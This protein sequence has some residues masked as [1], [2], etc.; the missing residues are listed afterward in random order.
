MKRFWWAAFCLAVMGWGGYAG[1]QGPTPV[2]PDPRVVARQLDYKSGIQQLG[3]VAEMRGETL[4]FLDPGDARKLLEDIWENPP[5]STKGVLGVLVPKGF[6]PL[7]GESWASVVSYEKSG[8]VTDDDADEIDYNALLKEMQEATREESARRA[9]EGYP[10]IELVGWASKPF[11]EKASHKLHWA[12]E[13]RFDGMTEN[14]LNYNLRALGRQG[15]L[16]LNFVAGMGQLAEIRAAIP[17]VMAEVNFKP[18]HRYE[19]FDSK[20]DD[21]A[22]YGLAALITGGVL[23]K[24]G[25]FGVIL[26][27]VVALKKFAVVGVIAVIGGIVAFVR[28]RRARR[29]LS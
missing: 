29:P 9:K 12:K 17:T 18:G 24:V 1:A 26:A 5:G 20:V 10:G 27:A 21:V 8:Y 22:G 7:R 28:R 3:L 15:V 19:E 11:Y 13:L 2:K 14:T 4:A 16:E 23:K 25:F 6:D